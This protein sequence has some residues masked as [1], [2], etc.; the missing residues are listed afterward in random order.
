MGYLHIENLYRNQTVLLFRECFCLEKIHGTSAHICFNPQDESIRFFSGGT[1]QSVFESIFDKDAL[2]VAFKALSLP[3]DKKI[4][5]YGES[6]GGKE[7][8]MSAT[9][10][11]QNKFVAF[12]VKINDSWLDVPAAEKIVLSLGLEFVHYV[13]VS[14]DLAELDK[15]RDKPSTQAKR[16]GILEDKIQEGIIIRPLK[17][18][19][20]NNG[21]RVIAKHKRAEFRETATPR[22][23]NPEQLKVL[24]DA[25]AIA[26]EWVTYHRLEHVLQKIEATGYEHIPLVIA[27]MQE[28]VSREGAGEF[29]PS[30]EV[31]KAISARTVK[32]FKEFLQAKLVAANP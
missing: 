6:Y 10:G 5:V 30:K 25:Q 26:D 20:L 12:D 24:E 27:A 16:N 1:K 4:I 22:E 21:D 29:V 14:T 8:G 32:L 2:L 17:E 31:T 19:K 23:V 11:K 3:L 13:K 15:Q 9:Y 7:Q 18:M 28:D